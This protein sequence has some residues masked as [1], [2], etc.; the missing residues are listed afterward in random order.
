MR[1][2]CS[3]TFN[4]NRYLVTRNQLAHT[5]IVSFYSLVTKVPPSKV[6]A[7]VA[8]HTCIFAPSLFVFTGSCQAQATIRISSM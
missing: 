5:Q 7:T 3:S 8:I 2:S 6:R 4:F 1:N